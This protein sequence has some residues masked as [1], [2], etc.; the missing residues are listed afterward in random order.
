[1]QESF[2]RFL[3]LGCIVE[4]A[5]M[6]AMISVLAENYGTRPL[7]QSCSNNDH[8]RNQCLSDQYTNACTW[9]VY[10]GNV[11]YCTNNFEQC[12]NLPH[13]RSHVTGIPD[14]NNDRFER[15]KT[16]FILIGL[17]CSWP[18]VA[19]ALILC[20]QRIPD[21]YRKMQDQYGQ[22]PP[23]IAPATAPPFGSTVSVAVQHDSEVPFAPTY[24]VPVIFQPAV[25]PEPSAPIWND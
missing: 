7:K 14:K 21:C 11:T 17:T 22:T 25:M 8:N 9:C 19:V 20:V 16:G 4:F 13:L 12:E 2:K 3:A 5:L 24:T 15:E 1:M 6:I 10:R 18:F 23:A